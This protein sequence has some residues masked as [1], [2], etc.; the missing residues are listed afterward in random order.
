MPDLPMDLDSLVQSSLRDLMQEDY[1]LL[2]DTFVQDGENRLAIL[3]TSLQQEHWDA[4]RQAAHSFKGSCGNMGAAALQH[5]CEDA[6]QA[7]LRGDAATA[8]QCF[9]EICRL[10]QR[11]RSH[12]GR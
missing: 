4:F 9:L 6:E 1:P 11:V 3:S 8:R 12:L 7:G 2:L 10:F 5:A